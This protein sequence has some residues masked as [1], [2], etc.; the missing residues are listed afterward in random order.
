MG[1]RLSH[2]WPMK[3]IPKSK[4]MVKYKKIL[5]KGWKQ[6]QL[7]QASLSLSHCNSGKRGEQSWCLF[8]CDFQE[9]MLTFCFSYLL[10]VSSSVNANYQVKGLTHEVKKAG[11]GR[12]STSYGN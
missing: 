5:R 3:D 10:A 9:K 4:Y 12:N 6:E 1:E 8:C 11:C 2:L 7:L